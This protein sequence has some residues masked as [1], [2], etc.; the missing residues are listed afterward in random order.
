MLDLGKL[1]EE[2]EDLER[3]NSQHMFMSP[4][5]QTS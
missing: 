1:T 2:D 4:R 5:E 3:D